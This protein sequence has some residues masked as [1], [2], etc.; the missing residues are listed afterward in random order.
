MGLFGTSNYEEIIG[1]KKRI[2]EL[3]D[4]VK[5]KSQLL[6]VNDKEIA[7]S[8]QK[9]EKKNKSLRKLPKSWKRLKAKWL[10]SNNP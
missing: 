5:M 4:S 8:K 3:N 7:E 6:E 10:I 1:L 2:E 9:L